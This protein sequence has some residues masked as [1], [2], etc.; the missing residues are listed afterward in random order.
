MYIFTYSKVQQT[1]KTIVIQTKNVKIKPNL[2]ICNILYI[3][4]T[5]KNRERSV[6]IVYTHPHSSSYFF[7]ILRNLILTV[8]MMDHLTDALIV[9]ITSNLY[10][11]D[12]DGSF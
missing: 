8:D 9:E 7:F 6:G 3:F 1:I 2:V 4:Y 11:H 5:S 10:Y 12:H